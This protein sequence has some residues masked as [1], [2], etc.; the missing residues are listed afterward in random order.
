MNSRG[1]MM[2]GAAVGAGVY[3]AN[4]KFRKEPVTTQEGLL[5]S[6]IGACFALLPDLLEPASSPNHRSFFHGVVFALFVGYTVW[7]Y[8][9]HLKR[10]GKSV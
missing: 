10:D 3:V 5:C 1:H 9:Q 7:A 2:L 8:I 4:K 6:G